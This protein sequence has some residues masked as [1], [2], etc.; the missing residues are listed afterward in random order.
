ML[1][2]MHKSINQRER[3]WVSASAPLPDF[4]AFEA[5]AGVA[6]Q[7]PLRGCSALRQRLRRC[8]LWPR[9]RR[10]LRPPLAGLACALLT[11]AF[12]SRVAASLSDGRECA[13]S[14]RNRRVGRSPCRCAYLAQSN[15]RQPHRQRDDTTH[16]IESPTTEQRRT[17]H[18]AYAQP[19]P[20]R[21]RARSD[22]HRLVAALSLSS[23]WPSDSLRSRALR[24]GGVKRSDGAAASLAA[25]ATAAAASFTRAQR[26]GAAALKVPLPLPPPLLLP[27]PHT[28]LPPLVRARTNAPLNLA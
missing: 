14:H 13:W 12:R 9:R 10:A 2:Q 16:G 17:P 1:L 15:S 5:G 19:Q 23:S 11:C 8:V 7:Q 4:S 20:L 6:A 22:S 25:V 24:C 28:T 26:S 3:E 21:T 18:V 27:L